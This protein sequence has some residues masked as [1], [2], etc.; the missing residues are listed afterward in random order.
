MDLCKTYESF[1]VPPQNGGVRVIVL[2][3]DSKEPRWAWINHFDDEKA[4]L[5]SHSERSCHWDIGHARH[6]NE[7]FRPAL[8]LLWEDTCW[9]TDSMLSLSINHVTR[10]TARYSW[11]NVI[12]CTGMSDDKDGRRS[13][14]IEDVRHVVDFFRSYGGGPMG[15]SMPSMPEGVQAVKI[16]CEGEQQELGIE[17]YAAIEVPRN[18]TIFRDGQISQISKNAGQAMLLLPRVPFVSRDDY[19][20]TSPNPEATFMM[21]DVSLEAPSFGLAPMS[22]QNHVGSVVVVRQNRGALQPI[23]VKAMVYFCERY[24]S[25]TFQTNM[26]LGWNLDRKRAVLGRMT[27]DR[28]N[29]Y[30]ARYL[31]RYGS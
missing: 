23:D 2:P 13:V 19:L 12:L 26:E 18:S 28:Y 31:R 9:T 27:L 22:W 17:K 10:N 14:G 16:A 7:V 5:N 30:C 11:R 20:M 21:R 25:N 24:M 4:L 8:R 15:Q 3:V 1:L 29:E 6:S